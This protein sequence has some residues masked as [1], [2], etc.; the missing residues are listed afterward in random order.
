M[1]LRKIN[2]R[3]K[4][5]FIASCLRKKKR[6]FVSALLR[7]LNLYFQGEICNIYKCRYCNYYHVGHKTKKVIKILKYINTIPNLTLFHSR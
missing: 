3:I 5:H 1:V 2:G 4:G 6:S 7:I